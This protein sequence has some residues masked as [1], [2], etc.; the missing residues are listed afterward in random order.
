MIRK[1]PRFLLVGLITLAVIFASI[2]YCGIRGSAGRPGCPDEAASA[3]SREAPEDYA[4]LKEELEAALGEWSDATYGIFFRD[5]ASGASFGINENEPITAASTVKLPVV[6]YLNELVAAGELDWDDRVTYD[7][8]TDWQDG[9]GILQ[10]SARDGDTF[11]LR[12]LANLA[13][14]ISDNIAYKILTRH[15]GRVNIINFMEGKGGKIVFPE[16]RNITC[17]RDM[18]SYLEAVMTFAKAHPDL[19]SRLLD[20]M[21]HPIYHVGIPGNLPEELIV[22]HKEGDVQGIAN[23][24]GIVFANKPYILVVLSRGVSDIDEGFA[25][26]AQI[27]KIVYDYQETLDMR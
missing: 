14:T 8:D 24:V 5:I 27:S 23:D 3:A 15:L 18:G 12:V 4:A 19:G 11:S 22:A 20:D 6:L 26:I 13:I 9:A 16:G 25:R 1:K 17:A 2:L 21:S 10:F 7:S